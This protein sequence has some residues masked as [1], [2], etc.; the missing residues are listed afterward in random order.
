MNGFK[1]LEKK[2]VEKILLDNFIDLMPSFY[3]ME[4]TFLSGIYKRYGD[5]EGGNIVI[6]FARDLHLKIL[7]KREIDL[8]FNLSLDEF[9]HNHKNAIQSKQK[10]IT[11]AKRI[12]PIVESLNKIMDEQGRKELIHKL[13]KE[14]QKGLEKEFMLKEDDRVLVYN[15]F[16]KL[17]SEINSVEKN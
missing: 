15:F 17:I 10:I 3:E 13:R 14:M 8:S 1:K 5:L 16:N 9:W 11:I 2:H 12:D 6:F 4:S 7:R